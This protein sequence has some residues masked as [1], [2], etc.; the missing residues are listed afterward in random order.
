MVDR[1]RAMKEW[2]E[3]GMRMR[4]PSARFPIILDRST[5]VLDD[6]AFTRVP[7]MIAG[8]RQIE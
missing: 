7:A 1:D 5:F 3:A 2:P 4:M 6:R 8:V